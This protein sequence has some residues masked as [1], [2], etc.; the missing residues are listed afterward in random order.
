MSLAARLLL[1]AALV[2]GP[3]ATGAGSGPLEA[4]RVSDQASLPLKTYLARVE[5]RFPG[6]G[7]ALNQALKKAPAGL[8]TVARAK[9]A[10]AA[11]SADSVF[12]SVSLKLTN[13]ADAASA[14]QG[15]CLGQPAVGGVY[16]WQCGGGV[17]EEGMGR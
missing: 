16:I 13:T 14:W 3:L 17:K 9:A 2:L 10:Y 15:S 7:L 8:D 4:F 5:A 1:I 12:I 11:L 6:F